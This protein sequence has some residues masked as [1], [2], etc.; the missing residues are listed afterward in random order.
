[1]LQEISEPI[2]SFQQSIDA[3]AQISIL[4]ADAFQESGA[5]T[6]RQLDGLSEN[7]HITIGNVAH[8]MV[9]SVTTIKIRFAVGR[10]TSSNRGVRELMG[11]TAAHQPISRER[12]FAFERTNELWN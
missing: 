4:P 10:R 11:K 5:L 6:D 9:R 12:D 3:E 1:L 8:R 2:M 7:L